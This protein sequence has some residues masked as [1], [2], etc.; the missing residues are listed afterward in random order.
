MGNVRPR[1]LVTGAAGNVGREVV[2]ALQANGMD[3]CAAD[4]SVRKIRA[5]HGDSV[6]AVVLDYEKFE[7]FTPA[8]LGCNALFLV[9]P[10]SIACMETT[11]LPFIDIARRRG[12]E[13]I[14]FLS[15]I[16]ASTNHLV[17][18]HAVEKYIEGG[19]TSYTLLRPGFFSQNLGVAYREDIAE[20]GRLFLPAGRGRVAFVDIRDVAEVA[21]II[22]KNPRPHAEA[23][24][25]CTGTEALSFEE[26]ARLMTDIIRRPIR[27][28]AATIAGYVRHLHGRGLPLAQIAVQTVLH[29]GL[30][31]GHTE[32]L[33]PTL[34]R[35]L[36]RKPRTLAAYVRESAELW[37]P[38][39][40]PGTP[41]GFDAFANSATR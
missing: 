16:G 13:H 14:V 18:H 2:W 10:P 32:K 26:T 30:R 31:Y 28:E 37:K 19:D 20:D 7:T 24:Y 1:T 23:A 39:E 27:Y 5:M 40:L 29:V 12:I 17:P 3:L 25:T 4:D 35:L 8:L 9:R 36:G 11:L 6:D 38:S 41:S 34:E 21:A 33:D 22:L 15:V